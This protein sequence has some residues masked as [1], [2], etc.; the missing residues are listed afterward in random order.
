[1]KI[2]GIRNIIR[3]KNRVVINKIK[4]KRFA[5]VAFIVSMFNTVAYAAPN[6]G[7]ASSNW[8]RAQLSPIA[9]VITLYLLVKEIK[10]K[11]IVK[12]LIYLLL[13][14]GVSAIIAGPDLILQVG[15]WL[16]EII[17]VR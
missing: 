17:G 10:N 15:Q 2:R 5:A 7:E 11:N 9:P 4:V 6:P 12:A 16:L 14:G 1:M 8:I 13:G 3:K